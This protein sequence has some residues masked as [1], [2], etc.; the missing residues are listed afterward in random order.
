ML[1]DYFTGNE[2]E[3]KKAPA[4]SPLTAFIFGGWRYCLYLCVSVQE[5]ARIQEEIWGFYQ[6]DQGLLRSPSAWMSLNPASSG[7]SESAP[8]GFNPWRV[9]SDYFLMDF[10]GEFLKHRLLTVPPPVKNVFSSCSYGWM[11]EL[12]WVEWFICR[13]WMCKLLC[14]H[15]G[16]PTSMICDI[17]TVW[18]PIP[19]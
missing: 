8:E 17:T 5:S 4:D 6:G 12:H 15:W 14:G 13:G 16:G 2:K 7:V 9:Y 11:F 10:D 19:V 18:K 1:T 3:K